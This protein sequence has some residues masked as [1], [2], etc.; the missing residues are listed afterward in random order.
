MMDGINERIIK[1][2]PDSKI[3]IRKPTVRLTKMRQYLNSHLHKQ[4]E[5]D[6]VVERKDIYPQY[7]DK[8]KNQRQNDI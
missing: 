4:K 3:K 7:A 2:H 1:T 8:R 6:I 5:C